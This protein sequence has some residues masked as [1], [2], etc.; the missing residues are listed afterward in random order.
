M[1]HYNEDNNQVL[2]REMLNELLSVSLDWIS[3]ERQAL[4]EIADAVN[5][6]ETTLARA[7]TTAHQSSIGT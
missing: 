5:K 3:E 6:A 1:K 2:S 7:Q 4:Q